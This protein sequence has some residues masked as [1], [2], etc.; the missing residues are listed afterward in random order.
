MKSS[1]NF[2]YDGISSRDM[3]LTQVSTDDGLFEEIFLPNRNINEEKIKGRYKPY[4]QGVDYDPLSFPLSFYFNDGFDEDKVRE[5][6]RWL[7]Q[8]Y[9]K[10]IYFEDYPDRVFYC[11]YVGDSKLL[12]NGLEQGYVNLEMRCNSPFSYSKVYE[13][14][15]DFSAN[16]VD[17][18][19]LEFKNLGNL[20]CKPEVWIETLEAGDFSIINQSDSGREFKFTGLEI[21]E[22]V[23]VDNENEHIETDIV[24]IYRYDNFNDNYLDLPYGVNKLKIYGKCNI[25]L[26]Y[27]YIAI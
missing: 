1:L 25:R 20:N 17:G 7:M 18:M 11:M 23:Y 24:D 21:N 8:D 27:Q 12:H 2:N 3:G 16:T 6:K 13:E 4:H 10:V 26:R 9:Y 5:V 22:T 14:I 19:D 15:F